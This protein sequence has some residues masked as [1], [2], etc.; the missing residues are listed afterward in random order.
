MSIFTLCFNW[1]HF[2]FTSPVWMWCFS[3][4]TNSQAI[5]SCQ[6]NWY[7][8]RPQLV[9]NPLGSLSTFCVLSSVW[10]WSLSARYYI[11]CVME[12]RH[13]MLSIEICYTSS[14]QTETDRVKCMSVRLWNFQYRYFPQS[15]YSVQV[16][17]SVAHT[18]SVWSNCEV[19]PAIAV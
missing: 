17:L 16:L 3:L 13:I 12:D 10:D 6:L 7:L 19:F 11:E 2:L 4:A 5:H 14:R 9:N 8:R 18:L 15:Y 1:L